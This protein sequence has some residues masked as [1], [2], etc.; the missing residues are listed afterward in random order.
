MWFSSG[1]NRSAGVAVLQFKGNIID[2][3][4]G[5]NGGW[6]ILV[7]VDHFHFIIINIY[8]S[9]SKQ[10]NAVIFSTIE[11]KINQLSLT[12]PTAEVLWGGDFN[13]VMDESLDRWP[14]K[15][16]VMDELGNVCDRM[17][18]IDIWRHRNPNQNIYILGVIKIDLSNPA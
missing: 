8:A 13:T 1:S 7:E 3:F 9:N 5:A 11:N 4:S 2:H 17:G 16:R 10:N 18:L 12:F 6:I 14:P 15:D